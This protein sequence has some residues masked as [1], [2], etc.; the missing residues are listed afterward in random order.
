MVS[1]EDETASGKTSTWLRVL[2]VPALYSLEIW[3]KGNSHS[4]EGSANGQACGGMQRSD[5]K[6]P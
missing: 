3:S 4:E 6:A 2:V 1:Q 5:H